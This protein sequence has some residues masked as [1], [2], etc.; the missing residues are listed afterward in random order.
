MRLLAAAP[1]AQPRRRAW[2]LTL[3]LLAAGCGWLGA[4]GSPSQAG[5]PAEERPARSF[6]AVEIVRHARVPA[7]ETAI[8]VS[9]CQWHVSPTGAL[10]GDHWG[11]CEDF[12]VLPPGSPGY[13]VI[14]TLLTGRAVGGF[15]SLAILPP[16]P[17]EVD[18]DGLPLRLDEVDGR[19]EVTFRGR[20]HLLAPRQGAEIGA[21]PAWIQ[22][23]EDTGH[24][25]PGFSEPLPADVV[26]RAVYH[27]RLDARRLAGRQG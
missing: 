14:T 26:Y 13:L 9:A 11:W 19:L 25:D 3:G 2:L 24:F 16:L 12:K 4:A 8:A 15:S 27:G 1:L 22:P 6:L 23:P 21:A 5:M 18:L 17:A 10:Y 7:R 20:R